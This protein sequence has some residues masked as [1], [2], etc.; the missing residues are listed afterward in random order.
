M[1]REAW[2]ATVYRVTKTWTRL[3]QLSTRQ[4]FWGHVVPLCLAFQ[5]TA[6]LFPPWIHY[7][8]FPLAMY[9]GSSSSTVPPAPVSITILFRVLIIEIKQTKFVL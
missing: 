4:E 5:G 1:D 6:R 8:P 3:K 2:R 7:F 9:E